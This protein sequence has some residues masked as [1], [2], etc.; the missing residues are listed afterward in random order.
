MNSLLFINEC[1]TLLFDL[2]IRTVMNNL[3]CVTKNDVGKEII[4]RV[5]SRLNKFV[6]IVKRE[7][8]SLLIKVI[9]FT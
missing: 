1:T 5:S 4:I 3:E 2:K 7:L 9:P 8:N 6:E